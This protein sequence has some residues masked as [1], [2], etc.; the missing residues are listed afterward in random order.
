[1]VFTQAKLLRT[2]QPVCPLASAVLADAPL[3][4][5][6]RVTLMS[7]T[8]TV[9][10]G[11][12]LVASSIGFN[13][14]RYPVVWQMARSGDASPTPTCSGPG[15]TL[16]SNEAT[17]AES[18][19][20]AM[21]QPARAIPAPP[22]REAIK[23]VPEVTDK[24]PTVE[25]EQTSQALATDGASPPADATSQPVEQKP[26]VPVP[27]AISSSGTA[28]IASFDASVRRLPPVEQV[29]AA[30]RYA[31]QPYESAYPIYPS[32]GIQ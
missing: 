7:Q 3:A 1:M 31:S 13:I 6:D 15:P 5:Q 14:T 29:E 28:N 26:L 19:Q 23:P 25:T 16:P 18:P 9:V 10:F 20:L 27:V 8:A 11:M 24:I 17:P 22:P 21:E 12:I 30:P 32:T 2:V 4:S